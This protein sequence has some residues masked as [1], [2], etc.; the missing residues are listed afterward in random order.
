[1]LLLGD[2]CPEKLLRIN[3]DF[4]LLK[5]S[6]RSHNSKRLRIYHYKE[7]SVRLGLHNRPNL[8]WRPSSPININSFLINQIRV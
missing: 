4:M 1:M 2:E 6:F 3:K 8:L 5:A 7:I